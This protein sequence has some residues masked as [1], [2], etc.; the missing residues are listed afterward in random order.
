ML[1]WQRT[2]GIWEL[3]KDCLAYHL[4]SS[5]II[6]YNSFLLLCTY[7]Y[8]QLGLVYW[9]SVSP[10]L[11]GRERGNPAEAQSWARNLIYLLFRVAPIYSSQL[12]LPA[13]ISSLTCSSAPDWEPSVFSP[14]FTLISRRPI[15]D[16]FWGILVIS[17]IF[18]LWLLRQVRYHPSFCG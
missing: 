6:S 8:C 3:G 4:M 16:N 7:T 17:S 12:P 18:P 5:H 14:I 10:L 1:T 2:L 9:C 11:P 15:A 13:L